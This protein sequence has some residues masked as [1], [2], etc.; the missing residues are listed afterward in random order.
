MTAKAPDARRLESRLVLHGWMNRMLGYAST[1]ELLED[2]ED[3]D[4][5]FDGEGR[6]GVCRRLL[7]REGRM[8]MRRSTLEGYDE[9]IRRH[10]AAMNARRAEPV[11]LK[12]FQHLAA[13][14]TEILL[15]NR[16]DNSEAFLASLNEYAASL[17]G[18]TMRFGDGD[19]DRCAFWMAT[20]SGK[21]L[22][23]HIN[24]RQFLH[25]NDEPLDNILLIT[26]NERLTAQHLDEMRLSGIPCERFEPESPAAFGDVVRATEITKLIEEK[27]D[28]GVRID[29][30]SFEGRNL[31]FVD[32]GHKGAGSGVEGKTEGAWLK[33]RRRIASGGY[34]FEYSATFGQALAK[35]KKEEDELITSYG[36]S[37]LFDYSYRFF[38]GDGYGKDFR[39]LNIKDSG[40]QNTD[41]LLAGNLLSFYEQR[42][43][44]DEL[45]EKAGEYNLKSPL[46]ILIGSKVKAVYTE[47]KRSKSDVYDVLSFLH[48]FIRNRDGWGGR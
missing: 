31:I 4:E 9:N 47:D 24:Y 11:V 36:K 34:T 41:T 23:M 48:R 19:L 21:T 3:V 15:D 40:A 5:G 10:V 1:K 14:Y 18:E 13:L 39:L 28:G 22:L 16:F 44:Y 35:A 45:G 27:K 46:W 26:P 38:Y 2:L 25:Y 29:V 12:Y 7:S 33:I 17:D 43:C 30:D 37:I 8:R 42:L 20:G 32:E 6:S